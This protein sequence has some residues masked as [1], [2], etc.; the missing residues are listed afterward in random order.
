M[1]V[2]D[3]RAQTAFYYSTSYFLREPAKQFLQIDAD[4]TI[5]LSFS[6]PLWLNN[7]V[8]Q[9]AKLILYKLPPN[10]ICDTVNDPFG[11]FVLFPLLE[12]FNV[13]GCTDSLPAVA[14]KRAVP[15]TS[16]CKNYTQIDITHIA[17][18]WHNN[19]LEN[20]GVLLM[21]KDCAPTIV[22]ASSRHGLPQTHPM[23]RLTCINAKIPLSLQT[24]DCNVN[25]SHWTDPGSN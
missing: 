15:F 22:Y 6:L 17:R 1:S 13:C 20:N 5:Y 9:R 19:N 8:V 3:L 7:W 10:H 23:L 4:H 16:S 12:P 25:V 21:G 11:R 2:I 14:L 24:V 18:D